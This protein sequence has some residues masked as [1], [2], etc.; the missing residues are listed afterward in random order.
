MRTMSFCSG[1]YYKLSLWT[2]HTR[3][4]GGHKS[5][6]RGSCADVQEYLRQGVEV[7][8]CR[9]ETPLPCFV[10]FWRLSSMR[11]DHICDL[12]VQTGEADTTVLGI[13]TVCRWWRVPV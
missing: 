4:T 1:T 5:F 7:W 3:R 9:K 6:L 10:P 11:V 12:P 8:Q 2:I 13:C